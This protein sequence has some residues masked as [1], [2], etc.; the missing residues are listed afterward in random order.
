MVIAQLVPPPSV[1]AG[2]L[3]K[4]GRWY[5]A[6]DIG[7][8]GTHVT[9]LREPQTNLA[10]VFLMGESGTGQKLKLWR[11]AAAANAARLPS[12]SFT[13]STSLLYFIPH[14]N[15]RK[16][17]LFCGGHST[18][19][20]GRMLWLGGAW[21]TTR[22]CQQAYAFDPRWFPDTTQYAPWDSLASMAE[23]RW[24]PTATALADGRVL[25]AA[26][27]ARTFMLTFGGDSTTGRESHV[28]HPLVLA[29]RDNWSDTTTVVDAG[30]PTNGTW[31]EGRED[32]GL[33]GDR[34]GRVFLF[35]GRK[36]TP[37]SWT[38]FND[39]WTVYAS[40]NTIVHDDSTHHW[41]RCEV[42]SVLGEVPVPRAKFA[43]AW[44]G[45]DNSVAGNRTLLHHFH[46]NPD[47][48]DSIVVYIHGGI[49]SAG[50][51][52]GDLWR[53]WRRTE[54]SPN[55]HYQWV[56]QKL[57]D[58]PA[59]ARYGHTMVY[60]PG[61]VTGLAYPDY[62]RLIMFGG[63]TSGS[64]L[65][66]N[67]AL[68][69]QIGSWDKIKQGWWQPPI[70]ASA[71]GT[72]PA[73]A[74]HVAVMQMGRLGGGRR[75]YVFG[76]ENASGAP[77]DTAVWYLART[78]AALGDTS[79][80]WA[81]TPRTGG[82]S[83]R[84]RSTAVWFEDQ[85]TLTLFGGDTTGTGGYTNQVWSL[86]LHPAI[87]EYGQW[88]QPCLRDLG[89][90]NAP[91]LA[92]AASWG[93]PGDGVPTRHLEAFDPAGSSSSG[94]CC[95]ASTHGTWTTLTR[96]DSLSARPITDYPLLFVLPDGRLFSAGLPPYENPTLPYKRF[97]NLTSGNWEDS[98]SQAHYDAQVFGSAVMYR[99]GKILRAGVH[100]D[101][102]GATGNARTETISIGAGAIPG[103]TEFEPSPISHTY[104]MLQRTN[105]NLTVLPTGD[106]LATGGRAAADSASAQREPQIWDVA[107]GTWNDTASVRLALDPN[108]RNYHS[109]AI[110]LP[111]GRVLTTGGEG[112]TNDKRFSASV[113]E[114]PYLF[115]SDDSYAT[116]PAQDGPETIPFGRTFTYAL[117]D[118]TRGATIKSVALVRPGS[119]THAFDQNQ[120]YVPL[121]FVA[122]SNPARLLIQTPPNANTAPPGEYMLFVVDSLG[123][124]AP[125]VPSLA[126]WTIVK[127]QTGGRDSLDVIAP[128][129]GS[130]LALDDVSTCPNLSADLTLAWTAPADDDT[131]GFSGLATAYNLRYKLN[132]S[133][134]PN[135]NAWTAIPT[136]APG[137]LGAQEQVVVSGLSSA[138]WYR[139]QLKAVGDNADTSSL[140]NALVAKPKYCEDDGGGGFSARPVGA[141]SLSLQSG[142]AS[143]QGNTTFP[144]VA[145]GT[146]ATD[147]LQFEG[148]PRLV[149]E[150]R[151]VTLHEGGTR[152][153]SLDRVRLLAID[154]ASGTEAAATSDGRF[155]AGVRVPPAAV[156]DDAGRDLLAAATG[157]ASEPL[158]ADSGLVVNVSL[159]AARDGS[160]RFLLLETSATGRPMEGV[161]VE[162]QQASGDWQSVATVHPRRLWSALAVP[163]GAATSVRL[164]LLGAHAIRYAGL[165]DS[166]STPAARTAPLIHATSAS[167]TDWTSQVQAADSLNAVVQAG[168][169]LSLRF[170]DLAPPDG[171]SRD[172]FMVME[173]APLSASVAARLA[174]LGHTGPAVVAA[175]RLYQNV[176]NPF[177]HAT[178][179]AFDLPIAADVKLDIF[180]AQGRRMREFGG[181]Y[182]SGRY[183]IGWD[184]RDGRG[185]LVPPGVYTYRL[186]AGHS[187]GRRK[188]VVI[189]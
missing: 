150:T 36:G 119:A 106:V 154:H 146:F 32:H 76:G 165:L 139:F 70:D 33:A 96:Q 107:L 158:Y 51:A 7:V 2:T 74:G 143:E 162:A 160:G 75:M 97:F 175:F 6:G 63:R 131:I 5:D 62:A 46:T 102:D 147:A 136:D 39:V 92:G 42:A 123:S 140:S 77:A 155:V 89:L 167:G 108:P 3:Y 19:A 59:T 78:D 73:R 151:A 30:A 128:R 121:G 157:T 98:T 47:T 52:L 105:H 188:M 152:G 88:T 112:K 57:R 24:Y 56:W 181:R 161:S 20:D 182:E 122:R 178:E 168:D 99:P 187:V 115:R 169:S 130:Y 13:D 95:T 184:L 109:A 67:A 49:D 71:Y 180:D 127:T 16:V 86:A 113:Y 118:S 129:G 120:R 66:S 17:D 55:A 189:P 186:V 12:I 164:R 83:P 172:W 125:R 31:P 177:Q 153:L 148:A 91:A 116:R 15:D 29:G 101:G 145:T 87:P 82:P 84:T 34:A 38:Y 176:P 68:A 43:I 4:T 93:A 69:C 8:Q 166:A 103:W 94:G 9:L 48:T 72:P 45:L 134:E 21:S 179:I 53:G 81:R 23:E 90:P 85:V 61:P 138:L 50:N 133:S 18:L 183:R 54:T 124:D 26:G 60:D 159:P 14:P 110:L 58:D 132:S 79:Y 11:F 40:G 156:R 141:G 65:A 44:A 100:S 114:P 35:F 170:Q 126:R 41:S 117:T 80:V 149:A 185:S 64:A 137:Q 10:K 111:D 163:V 22:P 25:A 171:A 144:G 104:P 27:T 37:G 1:L 142:G 28:L 174:R 135:F 173:G